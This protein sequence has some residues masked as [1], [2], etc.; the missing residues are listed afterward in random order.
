MS[1]RGKDA[2]AIIVFGFFA[3]MLDFGSVVQYT[4]LFQ[5]SDHVRMGLPEPK[6]EQERRQLERQIDEELVESKTTLGRVFL[7]FAATRNLNKLINGRSEA[8]S[9]LKVLHGV[10]MLTMMWMILGHAFIFAMLVPVASFQNIPWYA[11]NVWWTSVVIAGV[12]SVD[13]FFFLSG[14]LVAYLFLQE[15]LAKRGAVHLLKVYFHRYYRLVFPVAAITL[16]AATLYRYIGDGP[17]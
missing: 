16:F 1:L 14:F 13:V 8:D 2:L 6:N 12:L 9:N 15:L 10:R 17:L 3:F 7:S 5:R 4:S 11:K